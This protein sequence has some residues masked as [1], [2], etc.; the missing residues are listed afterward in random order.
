MNQE[1]TNISPS[2]IHSMNLILAFNNRLLREGISKIL[3]EDETVHI[4]AEASNLLELIQSC[5]EFDFDI[6]LLD[7]EL[8]GLKLS[9]ILRLVKN[10]N[11]GKV[12]L[13]IPDKFDQYELINA[14]LSGV[15]GYIV[16]DANSIQLKK[17][18]RAVKD[19]QLWVERKM[20]YRVLDALL[21]PHNPKRK[22]GDG[23]IYN[24]TEA[25]IKI[26]KK[27]LDGYSNKLIAK[28]L[29]LSE[30][31]VKFHLSKIFKKLSVKSRSELILY[32]F[33]EGIVNKQNS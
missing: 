10:K 1:I 20:M 24:L 2:K 4:L 7:V 15:R 8:Q 14:I 30:M 23:P 31:T 18:I 25:E 32:C 12:I 29:Y 26:V 27:V 11:S 3:D 33:R 9:K 28:E 17:A 21:S 13:I 22:K 5:E 6:L 16:M 19:G